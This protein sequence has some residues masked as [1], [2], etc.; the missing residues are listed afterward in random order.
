MFFV[1][2]YLKSLSQVSK[3]S[4]NI[5]TASFNYTDNFSQPKPEVRHLLKYRKNIGTGRLKGAMPI[6]I[7]YQV[8]TSIRRRD[9]RYFQ[10]RFYCFCSIK[11]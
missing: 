6:N 4:C 5:G 11:K 2:M 1:I 7:I 10:F 9:V 3:G 8:S